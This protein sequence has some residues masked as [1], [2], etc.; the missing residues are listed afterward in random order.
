[1]KNKVINRI[2]YFLFCIFS[3]AVIG[4]IIW[5]FMKL[6]S[7]GTT[8]V[9]KTI[10]DMINFPYYTLCVCTIGG[11]LLG[12]WLMLT[13]AVPDELDYVMMKVK[14]DKYYPYNNVLLVCVSALIPLV[15]GGSIGP[16]A[17]LTGV[18]VGLCYWA[19][20]HMKFL[21]K[22]IPNIMD[23]GISSVLSIVF[24]TPL[25]GLVAPVEE[26]INDNKS[27]TMNR[28]IKTVSN[29]IAVLSSFGVFFLMG[30]LF[31]TG[32]GLPRIGSYNITNTERLFG[33]PLAL[34]GVLGGIIFI[35]YEKITKRFFDKFQKKFSIIISTILGGIILGIM[36]TYFPLTMFSGEDSISELAKA[37]KDYAPWV[38]ILSGVLK[39]I[40]TNICIKSG[41]KGGHFF[42]V[43]FCAISI[44]YG[45]AMLTSLDISF[46]LAVITAAMMGVIMKKPL[47]VSL[48]LLMCFDIRI[49]PWIV[50]AA[51]IGSII[52]TEKK[53]AKS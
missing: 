23:L 30:K 12:L 3:G 52:P 48:L 46:C 31:G 16:E 5:A 11:I 33:I 6:M 18:I 50:L 10:P 43:I 20:N 49:I 1:M 41:W 26:K 2:V 14:K 36:G 29:I 32:S 27:Y 34:V 53:K 7:L 4:L 39:L 44:G 40:L 22:K 38:L 51:F 47:A 28:G 24:G 15:F 45:V 35:F 19:G 17:G 8:L 37:Y 25:F 9:W 42:P 13:N 21:A